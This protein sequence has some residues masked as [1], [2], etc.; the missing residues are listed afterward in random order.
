MKRSTADIAK[1]I[2]AENS[3]I[4]MEM[5]ALPLGQSRGTLAEIS[6]RH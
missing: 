2:S 3:R 5:I 4:L 6:G 1:Q